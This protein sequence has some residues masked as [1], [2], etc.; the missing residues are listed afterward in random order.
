MHR[1]QHG[2]RALFGTI[3][4]AIV[5]AGEFLERTREQWKVD[6]DFIL[7]DSRTGLSDAAGICTILL[8]DVVVAMFTANHQ[9]LYGTRDI[10]RLA[11]Q[12]RQGLAHRRMALTVLPL[13]A[14]FPR[15]APQKEADA[16]LERFAEAF[17]ELLTIGF[18]A[19][20]NREA[21]LIG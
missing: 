12:A 21:H 2:W 20:S 5:V 6:Y 14:R 11:Q 17:G 19:R 13:P 8:S 1:M 16:W 7:I 9:S 3:S 10:M 18:R 4:F 15:K